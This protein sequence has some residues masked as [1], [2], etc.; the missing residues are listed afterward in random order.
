MPN[1][2]RLVALVTGASRGIGRAIAIQ[3]AARGCC[4]AVH[5]AHNRNAAETTLAGLQG[6]GHAV[7]AANAE[8]TSELERLWHEVVRAFGRVD[9][10][11]NN[12]G[13]FTDHPP[14][15][16]SSQHW[17]EEWNRT[18]AINLLAPAHLCHFAVHHMAA[19][20][21]RDQSHGR[22]RIVN[23][24]S[25]GAFRGEPHSPA[26]GASK[27]GLNSLSQSLARAVA[28]K[29]IYV[30]CLAPGWVDTDMAAEYLHGTRYSDI[31]A[32]Q[33]LGRVATADEIAGAVAFCAMDAPPAMTGSIIDLNG[34]S[35][36]RT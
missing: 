2:S 10:L 33:P 27:A 29:A 4:V 13:V 20:E 25:R 5:Y 19:A 15:G 34:A 9:I 18:I 3:L 14:L 16:T 12:A 6:H 36:L 17:N 1:R 23:L 28:A 11:V 26:Y 35:Y 30:F 21:L 32:E 24:S 22:G 7:F 8:K 31:I